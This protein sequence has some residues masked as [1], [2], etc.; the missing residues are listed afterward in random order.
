MVPG[1]IFNQGN[2]IGIQITQN[3]GGG[4][5][6]FPVGNIEAGCS[7]CYAVDAHQT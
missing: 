4:N 6:A 5:Q 3:P 2:P 7:R 1:V